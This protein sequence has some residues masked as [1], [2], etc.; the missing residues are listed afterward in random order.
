MK[1]IIKA[2]FSGGGLGHGNGSNLAPQKVIDQLEN[3]FSNENGTK[4]EY[5]VQKVENLDESNIS[6]SHLNIQNH[7]KEFGLNKKAIVLGG[8]HSITD[9]IVR[10]LKENYNE[11]L[12]FIVFDA[13]PDLMDNFKPPSQE[14]YLRTLLEDGI[15]KPENVVIVGLRN[16]DEEEIKYLEEKQLT[17]Y[18]SKDVFERGIKEI[19]QEILETIKEKNF[20]IY[21]SIDIDAIDPAFA[22]GT[23]YIE[24]GGMTSRELI[25]AVQKI[26]DT[27]RVIMS[28]IVEINPEKDVSDMTSMLGAKLIAELI[29]Y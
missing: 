4:V 11:D 22:P 21:L 18:H 20:E 6:E 23:G 27:K 8:D 5:E 24:H 10:G 19:T 1:T 13:H 28:D 26:V 7:I 9:P 16:W 15:L 2:G 17:Y 25:Y 29:D 14:D 3:V 12:L